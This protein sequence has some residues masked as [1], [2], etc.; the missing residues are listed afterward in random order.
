MLIKRCVSLMSGSLSCWAGV[1]ST[2][3]HR[4]K[5]EGS[6]MMSGLGAFYEPVSISFEVLPCETYLNRGLA[7]STLCQW[8]R[9]PGL[10]SDIENLKTATRMPS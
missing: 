9:I 2:L 5:P 10:N 6:A 7:T 1:L 3:N 8:R 4:Y